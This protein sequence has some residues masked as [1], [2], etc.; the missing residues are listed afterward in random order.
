M[1]PKKIYNEKP[2][3]P[4]IGHLE[5]AQIQQFLNKLAGATTNLI[6]KAK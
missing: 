2:Q 6:Q 4:L 1:E 3:L 5:S